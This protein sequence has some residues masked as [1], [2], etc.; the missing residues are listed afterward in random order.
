MLEGMD[1]GDYYSPAEAARILSRSGQRI[2]ER[3]VRQMCADGEI[4]GAEQT[5]SGRWRLPAATV[6]AML[7]D[8]R[9]RQDRLGAGR[10]DAHLVS[11]EVPESAADMLERLLEAE[12]RAARLE[13]MLE[14]TEQAESSIRESLE[15]ERERADRLEA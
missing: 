8:R 4:T 12:R 15:R 2:G 7:Q 3:R 11:A 6:H 1:R 9:A 14:L 5:E 13:G 10:P